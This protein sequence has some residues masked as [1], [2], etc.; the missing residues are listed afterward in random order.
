MLRST[1]QLLG[2][3]G[4]LLGL[5]A[6]AVACG[7]P[8]PPPPPDPTAAPVRVE[9]RALGLAFATLPAGFKVTK[10]DGEALVFEADLQGVSAPVTVG[11]GAEE[12]GAISLVDRANAFGAEIQAA[13]GKFHGG[14]QLVTPFGSAYTV[15][16]TIEGGK[17]EQRRV[18]LLH[19]GDTLRLVTIDLRYPPGDAE[20]T[21]DRLMQLMA[22]VGGIEPLGSATDQPPL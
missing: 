17:V 10:N 3:A 22:L 20:T 7:R 21:R 11:V 19:P 2:S 13:G 8:A 1:R 16:A 4:F 15:R 14:N 6:L 5:G 18:L 9:N 12:S